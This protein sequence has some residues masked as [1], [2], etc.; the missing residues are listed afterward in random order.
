MLTLFLFACTGTG[1]QPYAGLKVSDYFGMDGQRL[2][3]YNNDDTSITWQLNIE[4]KDQTSVVDG[5]ELVTFEYSRSDTF[6]I[7][8]S[9]QY[10][11]LAGKAVYVHGYSLGAT[12]ELLSFDPPVALT[13]DDDAMRTG[14]SVVTETTDSGGAAWTFTATYEEAVPECPTTFSNDFEKCAR[15]VIDDGD[16]DDTTG[17]LFTGDY[18]LVNAWGPAY[19]TIPGWT[20][21]WELTRYDYEYVE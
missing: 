14:D 7:L 20:T 21:S 2:G 17:P 19:M 16:G 1:T 12:G 10:S 18:T 15:F 5:R 11:V 13:E 9:A 4:K 3:I 8:G 6:E